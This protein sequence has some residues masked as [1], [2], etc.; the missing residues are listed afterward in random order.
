[1]FVGGVG[2]TNNDVRNFS[3]MRLHDRKERPEQHTFVAL[4]AL[5]A[6]SNAVS[7]QTG[8]RFGLK[9]GYSMSLQYGIM[10]AEMDYTAKHTIG[11]PPRVVL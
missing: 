4:L 2:C 8:V 6:F 10:P 3:T 1:M 11:M 5:L 7:A 9:G